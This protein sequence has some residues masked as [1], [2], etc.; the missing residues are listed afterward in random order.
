MFVIEMGITCSCNKATRFKDAVGPCLASVKTK[1][2]WKKA[3]QQN[4]QNSLRAKPPEGDFRKAVRD[5]VDV[6]PI[7]REDE[8]AAPKVKEIKVLPPIRSRTKTLTHISYTPN[9]RWGGSVSSYL[10]RSS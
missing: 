7:E 5:S 2:R 1:T 10:G 3:R 8:P 6:D 9:R 4:E